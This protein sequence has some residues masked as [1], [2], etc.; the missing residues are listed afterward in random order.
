M[1]DI[2]GATFSIYNTWIFSQSYFAKNALWNQSRSN[3]IFTFN[4]LLEWS[5]SLSLGSIF[6][7]LST[8]STTGG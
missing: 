6:I 3:G 4:F 2:L 7:S 8:T 5:I 1:K